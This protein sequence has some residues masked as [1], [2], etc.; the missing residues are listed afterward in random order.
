V[1]VN[2]GSTSVKLAAFEVRSPDDVTLITQ[3]HLS[4]ESLVPR[5]VLTS[6]LA[7]LGA[8]PAAIAHRVVHG[9][10]RFTAAVRI[11]SSVSAAIH[12]LSE[13]APLHNPKALEWIEAARS[14]A[15]P[16]VVQVAAFDTAFSRPRP[17]AFVTISSASCSSATSICIPSVCGLRSSRRSVSIHS[18]RCE[19]CGQSARVPPTPPAAGN[20]GN[21]REHMILASASRTG[22]LPGKSPRH[23]HLRPG[24]DICP[25]A[26]T[27]LP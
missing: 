19:G 20:R 13:L 5:E 8:A 18:Q 3:D 6:F 7:K 10:R 26:L 4:G 9:G 24:P 12:S 15:G 16:D 21:P 22:T 25:F 2:S 27:A 23:R 17:V 11:D 1:T 14:V